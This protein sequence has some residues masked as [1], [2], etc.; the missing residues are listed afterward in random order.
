MQ[1][2]CCYYRD[3][4]KPI[5]LPNR[6]PEW[7]QYDKVSNKFMELNSNSTKV[8]TTPYKERL[9][10]VIANIISAKHKQMKADKG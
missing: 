5:S 2:V 7:P 4:N 6:I 3:P 10:K 8:M 1:L 9:D